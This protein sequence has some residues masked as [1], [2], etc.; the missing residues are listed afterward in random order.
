MSQ[1]TACRPQ[2]TIVFPWSTASSHGRSRLCSVR[3][4]A[5]C[6]ILFKPFSVLIHLLFIVFFSLQHTSLELAHSL[7]VSF[8]SFMQLSDELAQPHRW[9]LYRII[10]DFSSCEAKLNYN[11][12]LIIVPVVHDQYIKLILKCYPFSPSL[13]SLARSLSDIFLNPS[14]K[15]LPRIFYVNLP[16]ERFLNVRK[17]L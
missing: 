4:L 14:M 1:S 16:V 2:P 12:V 7:S 10:S 15:L 8:L 13:S 6:F 9:I 5:L 17:S 11:N 3:T